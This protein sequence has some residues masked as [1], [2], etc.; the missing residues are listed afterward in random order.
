MR[1]SDH[2]IFSL[3]N[4]L[5]LSEINWEPSSKEIIFYNCVQSF[6]DKELLPRFT[7]ISA[8]VGEQ[9]QAEK[10][11]KNKTVGLFAARSTEQLLFATC[12]QVSLVVIS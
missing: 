2:F 5:F 8:N 10:C 3:Q 12:H 7:R 11:D 4:T 9:T 1:T 6:S